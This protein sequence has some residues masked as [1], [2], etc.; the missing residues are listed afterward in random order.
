MSTASGD[1]VR[2]LERL[3]REMRP[4]LNAEPC[5]YCALPAGVP[6]PAG[7]IGWFREAE[8]ESVILPLTAARA[9]GLTIAFEA[10]WITLEVHSALEAVGLT[11][12]VAAALA[13]RGI[14]CNVVAALRHD[15]LFVPV[16]RSR[17]ALAVLEA[18]ARQA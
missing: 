9:A 4:R 5:A 14:P 1:P 18:L 17:E 12:A 16:D 15:H 7:A 10:A 11:A 3:L 6:L 2:D 8:G 13:D